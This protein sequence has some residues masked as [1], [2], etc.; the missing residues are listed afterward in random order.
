MSRTGVRN[1]RSEFQLTDSEPWSSSTLLRLREEEEEEEEEEEDALIPS[2]SSPLATATPPSAPSSRGSGERWRPTQTTVSRTRSSTAGSHD[3]AQ[4]MSCGRDTSIV[5]NTSCVGVEC[6]LGS[7][8]GPWLGG[9][10]PP[11]SI[12][13]NP[14]LICGG[15]RLSP[16]GFSFSLSSSSDLECQHTTYELAAR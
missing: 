10:L 6:D 16:L 13:R 7:F 1:G 2:S 5:E 3:D 14:P 11:M 9:R 15:R 4:R 8:G 12:P